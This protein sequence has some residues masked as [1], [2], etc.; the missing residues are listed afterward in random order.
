VDELLKNKLFAE[1]PYIYCNHKF[2]GL[3]LWVTS[4]IRIN[5]SRKK[6]NVFKISEIVNVILRLFNIFF[7]DTSVFWRGRQHFGCPHFPQPPQS[8]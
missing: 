6:I 3:S 5:L 7:E 2:D 8:Q 4:Q 1:N